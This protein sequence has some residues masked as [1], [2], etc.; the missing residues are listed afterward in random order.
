MLTLLL[1]D[2][3]ITKPTVQLNIMLLHMVICL[4]EVNLTLVVEIVIF[5]Q[6]K[7]S[8]DIMKMKMITCIDV[9]ACTVILGNIDYDNDFYQYSFVLCEDLSVDVF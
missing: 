8:K 7:K 9:M 4:S 3:I 5:F 2:K 1:G 6:I